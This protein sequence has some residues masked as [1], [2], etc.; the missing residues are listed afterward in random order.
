[1]H[2]HTIY[3]GACADLC[4]DCSDHSTLVRM[5]T[6]VSPAR[7][8]LQETAAGPQ[9][10]EALLP[11]GGRGQVSGSQLAGEMAGAALTALA[12]LCRCGSLAARLAS[13]RGLPGALL[14]ALRAGQPALLSAAAGEAW[15]SV[16]ILFC[17]E[18]NPGWGVL[19]SRVQGLHMQLALCHV[20]WHA[21]PAVCA[22]QV[23]AAH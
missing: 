9:T 10:S 15:C 5:A 4:C 11:P 6:A 21:W 3:C 13:T 19:H 20:T 14:G 12:A 23:A 16:L 22:I 17:P 18:L 1:M 8:S 7:P 2:N